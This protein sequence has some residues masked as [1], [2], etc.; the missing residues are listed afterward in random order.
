MKE[1][2]RKQRRAS[3]A[4]MA[5]L[6]GAAV[7]GCGMAVV[8]WTTGNIGLEGGLLGA[9]FLLLAVGLV[10]WAHHL[11]PEG[12]YMEEY[13][14][15]Q[16]PP[17]EEAVVLA[18]LDRGG[19]GR[20]RVLL[21]SLGAVGVT[22]GASILSTIRS[23]GPSPNSLA[24]TPW[25]QK[26]LVVDSDGRPVKLGDLPVGAALSVFPEG[27]IEAPYVACMLIHLPPGTN[28]PLKGRASWAPGDYICYSKV[29]S[30]AGCPVNL[31]NRATLDME[32]PCHQ[33]TFAVTHGAE[34]IFG[35][36]AGPLAQLPLSV[37]PDGSLR[38]AGDFSQ[39]PGPVFWHWSG[40][41]SEA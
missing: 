39:P 27:F 28:H 7:L 6:V 17:R 15:L 10:L 35:P 24:H 8:Y 40:T 38:S 36:A 11:L 25:R 2:T 9:C 19:I 4:V 37:D 5:C 16:S 23:F 22:I 32:C 21:G 1:Q 14:D 29:C 34:P 26:R 31:Y 18:T 12:P 30:H 33:S 3:N 41:T 20:R 13:P